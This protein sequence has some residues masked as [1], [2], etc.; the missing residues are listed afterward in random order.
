MRIILLVIILLILVYSMNDIYAQTFESSNEE[1]Y[2][3]LKIS[4]DKAFALMKI[5]G[6]I[7][8][9]QEEDI[10]YYKNGN[11][12]INFENR[13]ILLG[14]PAADFINITIHDRQ[15]N[16][17]IILIIQ[18]VDTNTSYAYEEPIE[19]TVAEKVELAEEQTGMELIVPLVKEKKD[20]QPDQKEIK[21]LTQIPERF[22][23]YQEFFF[24]VRIVD[25]TLNISN[26]YWND[27]GFIN[28]VEIIST[29]KD[30]LGTILNEFTGNTTGRG[31]YSPVNGTSFSFNSVSG[32]YTLEVNATKYFEKSATFATDSI[33]REF[34]VFTFIEKLECK[35]FYN[36]ICLNEC[37]FGTHP[38]ARQPPYEKGPATCSGI[39]VN[40]PPNTNMM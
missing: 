10:K 12:K 13:I 23:Y 16:L 40:Q 14:A 21:I 30:P 31:H 35:I 9:I 22:P 8:S 32:A 20:I 37:P 3:F 7:T 34:F 1:N 36:G 19:L 38:I 4:N 11:F 24:D 27:V 25:S 33:V 15:N 39:I 5:N 6:V 18:K 17:K 29:I 2:L 26:D 28:D